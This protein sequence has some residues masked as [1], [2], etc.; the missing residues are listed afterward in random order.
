MYYHPAT[1]F[2]NA[3]NDGVREI[4]MHTGVQQGDVLATFIYSIAMLDLHKEM[5]NAVRGTG[6]ATAYVDD[7]FTCGTFDQITTVIDLLDG[8]LAQ[9]S[10]YV[11]NDAKCIVVMGEVGNV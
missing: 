7:T 1:L 10:G 9:D 6:I 5:Q 4:E 2:F 11:R 8:D 3:G